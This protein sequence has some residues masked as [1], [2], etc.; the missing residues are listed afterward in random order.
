MKI[1]NSEINKQDN[2]GNNDNKALPLV[3]LS[4]NEMSTIT[5][6]QNPSPMATEPAAPAGGVRPRRRPTGGVSEF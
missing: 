5:G 1:K 2:T 3:P 4:D 6:G